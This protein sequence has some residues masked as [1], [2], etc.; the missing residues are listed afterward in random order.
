MRTIQIDLPER[1]LL[2]TGQT[3]DEF[4]KE[5]KFFLALKLFELGRISSGVAAEIAQLGR[6]AFLLQAGHAGVNLVDLDDE[7]LDREFEDV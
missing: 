5:A 1:L 4:V 7:E 6:V 2:G 3:H